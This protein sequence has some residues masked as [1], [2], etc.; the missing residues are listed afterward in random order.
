MHIR[1]PSLSI[2]LKSVTVKLFKLVY[3]SSFRRLGDDVGG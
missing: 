2:K 3:W 1:I